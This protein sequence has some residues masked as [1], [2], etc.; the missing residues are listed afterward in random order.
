MRGR[1]KGRRLNLDAMNRL[2]LFALCFGAIILAACEPLAYNPTPVAQIITPI[3]SQT[4]VPSRTPT[5]TITPPATM[6]PTDV[7]TITPPPAPCE[8]DAGQIIDFDDNFSE[9]AREN[10]RYRVYIPPCYFSLQK[11]FPVVYLFHGLSY[12]EQQFEDLGMIDALNQ[13]IRLGVLPPMILVMPWMGSIGQL[14]QFPPDPS[15]ERVILE[16]LI[17][18]VDRDFC[19]ISNRDHRAIGGISRGGF[20]A[21]SVAMRN[22]DVFGIVGGHSAFFPNDTVNIPPPFN[23]LE[24]ALNSTFLLEADLRIYMDNGAS[25]S[26]AQSQQLMSSRLTQR[27]IPHTYIVHPVGEHNEEYWSAHVEEYLTF[28]GRDWQRDYSQLPDCSDPSP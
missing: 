17:V 3:P 13:G 22:P 8:E 14:N 11:R 21:F 2:A 5:P 25:D 24:L 12:R 28:Y 10:L 26:S 18:P 27:E 6:T 7:A 4:P 9:I 1:S 20:W 15:Y 19:T 16:E 23:P